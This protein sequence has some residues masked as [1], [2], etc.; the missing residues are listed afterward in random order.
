MAKAYLCNS[1]RY[2]P[3]TD[4][5][6]Q[7]LDTLPSIAQGMGMMDL[8]RMF[9]SVP[10]VIRDESTRRAIDT[11]LIATNPV[12]QQTFF[13]QSGQSY[14]VSGQVFDPTKPF[15]VSLAWTDAAGTTGSGKQLVNDLNLEVTVMG[16]TYKGNVFSGPNSVPGGTA[17][18]LNNLESVFLPAGADRRVERGRSR[19]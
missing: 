2:L 5:A 6:T 19:G 14:E 17:D 15:R 11:P 3:F 10:R 4:P 18:S 16:Q 12:P 13:S 9:D 1:A 8:Q 7:A